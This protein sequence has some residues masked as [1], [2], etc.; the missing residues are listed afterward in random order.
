MIWPFV[1][2][3]KSPLSRPK[4]YYVYMT[5]CQNEFTVRGQK[6]QNWNFCFL[7]FYDFLGYWKVI[8][9]IFLQKPFNWEHLKHFFIAMMKIKISLWGTWI[10]GWD[11]YLVAKI[12]FQAYFFFFYYVKNCPNITRKWACL[13][14]MALKW[15]F[16]IKKIKITY[17]KKHLGDLYIA[18]WWSPT[19]FSYYLYAKVY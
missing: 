4:L 13:K 8:F 10:L 11:Y 7:L 14:S 3:K 15:E 17:V 9:R 16:M 19:V 1:W 12:E 5:R 6:K 2:F 18:H